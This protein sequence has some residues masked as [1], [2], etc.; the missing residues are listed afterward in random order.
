MTI[1]EVKEFLSKLQPFQELDDIALRQIAG[2]VIV[3]FY[4]KDTVIINEENPPCEYLQ[5]IK[6]GY[7]R[8]KFKES[9]K[10]ATEY[11]REGNSFGC[12]RDKAGSKIRVSAVEDTTCYLI[13]KEILF[14]I[15][16]THPSMSGY[17]GLVLTTGRKAGALRARRNK[18]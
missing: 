2:G 13:S 15:L 6:K 7:V 9:E 5:I 11:R 18:K 3:E 16:E 17:S 1:E 12:L 10:D 4:P 8:V 14:G